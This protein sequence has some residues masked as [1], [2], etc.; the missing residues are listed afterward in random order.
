VHSSFSRPAPTP[1]P[2]DVTLV[3]FPLDFERANLCVDVPHEVGI[4]FHSEC[5]QLFFYTLPLNREIDAEF[6]SPMR[7]RLQ[8]QINRL[9]KAIRGS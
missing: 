3:L 8:H 1:S 7:K 5:G 4:T 9:R 6:V 2:Q